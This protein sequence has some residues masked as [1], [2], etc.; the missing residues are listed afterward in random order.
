MTPEIREKTMR[1]LRLYADDNGLGLAMKEQGFDVMITASGSTLVTFAAC[2]GW[3]IATVPLGNMETNG[4]P[5]GLFVLAKTES[6][7]LRFMA[8]WHKMW[9]GIIQPNVPTI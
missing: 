1:E 6:M 5:Y 7:L 2:A 8:G 9:S 4:Q 3:P